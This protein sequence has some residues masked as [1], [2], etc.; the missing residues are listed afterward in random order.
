MCGIAGYFGQGDKQV[1]EKMTR[2][3][4]HRGPDD[5]G[6]YNSGRVGLGQRRLSIIDTSPAGHQPMANEN[7]NVWL[8]FNGEIY[9][10]KDLRNGLKDK[11]RFASQSDTEVI[12]HLYEEL[13]QE[14]FSKLEGMFA[15]ALYDERIDK[16]FLARDRMGKKPLYYGRFGETLVFGSELKALM[17]HP[18]FKKELDL[19]ALNKYLLYEY[20]PTPHSIFKN[21]FKL[22]P[23]TYLVFDG[24]VVVKKKFWSI[25]FNKLTITRLDSRRVGA[26]RA[27]YQLQESNVIKELDSKLNN[28][29]KS[30]LISDVPLGVFLSGGIDSSTIAYYAQKNSGQKI[31]TFSIGF[32][33]S[34]FDETQYARQVAKHLGTEHYEKILDAKDSLDLVPKIAEMLDEPLADAS[35]IPTFLLSKFTRERVTVALGGDGGDE[36]FCGYDTFVAHRLSDIYEKLPLFARKSI[37]EK[38]ALSLPTSF[39]NFS[40][41]FKAK[42]FISGFYGPK[43]YRNQRW[44]GAFDRP[45]RSALFTGDVWRE[46]A[47][48]NEFAEIDYY[49]KEVGTPD[50]YQQLTYQYLRT[51]MMDDIL[52]KVD[53]AS[54]FNSLEVRAPFL[55]TA[56]VDFAN[57]L[58]F[59]YKLRGLKTKYILK[60]LMEDKL[61]REIVQRKK[62]GFGIPLAEWLSGDLKPLV[63]ELFSEERIKRQD[64]FNY[65]YINKLLDD[66]FSRRADNR[67]L[68]WTLAVFQLW[69]EKWL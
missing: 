54:M 26:R 58:P 67:K 31:K 66:H 24:S 6:F 3:L 35:I 25:E 28:A 32:K 11:H 37:I 8:A 20:I 39:K 44:L 51:Y 46:L 4:V 17:E 14:V 9:N 64:L 13:G 10:F 23:A 43:E 56:V 45:E 16:L 34:S 42:K 15:I 50:Y 33:E 5:E 36:L 48:E 21:V 19:R 60:K 30:R 53:R 55:D 2:T 7:K 40:F 52:V 18:L 49:N 65:K 27:N 22:E 47:Q 57:S 68:I 12:L 41:D 38:I 62:K 69:R 1:L 61:P 63:L 59:E 29:V